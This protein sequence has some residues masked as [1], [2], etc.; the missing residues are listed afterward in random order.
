MVVFSA[1]KATKI[2][3]KYSHRCHSILDRQYVFTKQN[4]KNRKGE[5]TCILFQ[6]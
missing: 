1:E 6:K 3:K 2:K 4:G 5:I